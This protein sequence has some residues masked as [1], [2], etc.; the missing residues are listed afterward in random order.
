M[1]VPREILTYRHETAHFSLSYAYSNDAAAR[2]DPAYDAS[3]KCSAEHGVR[4][5][6]Y[7]ERFG[8][9]FERAWSL[10]L[11]GR[12]KYRKPPGV[13]ASRK[14][15]VYVCSVDAYGITFPEG[16]PPTSSF[17]AVRNTYRG[18]G[19]NGDPDPEQGR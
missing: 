7:V 14:Y 12:R 2:K 17:I 5:R 9:Y 1:S 10:Y 15:R 8:E 19:R 13:S 6:E 3:K 4:N 18:F 16:E 11:K